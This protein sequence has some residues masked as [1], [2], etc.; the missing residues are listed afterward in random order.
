MRFMIMKVKNVILASALALIGASQQAL[1]VEKGDW[2]LHVRAININP[3][4]DSS[5]LNVSGANLPGTGV[6][7]ASSNSLDISIGYMLTD[8]FAVELL[9]DLSSRHDVSVNGLPAAL[10]VPNGTNVVSSNVL[11][12]TVFAQYQFNP[13]GKIRPYAGLGVNYT[14]FFNSDLTAAA[15]SA[16]GA[17]NL[18]IDSSFGLAGQFGIDFEMKNDWSFNVDAKYIQIDTTAS[19]DSA[20]G[21]VSVDIDINPWVLGIGFGKTF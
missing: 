4:D 8:N 3:D 21:P 17:S 16:L 6:S 1:A 5:S 14:L 20:L 11:P 13:K 7:V 15:Q 19:F 10:N 2:L 18:D 12:P 9:A